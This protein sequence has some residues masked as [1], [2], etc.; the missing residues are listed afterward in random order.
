MWKKSALVCFA[1]VGFS[2]PFHSM[3]RVIVAVVVLVY[4]FDSKERSCLCLAE[5][6]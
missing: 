4:R 6:Y 3:Q 1:T 5:K 2:S